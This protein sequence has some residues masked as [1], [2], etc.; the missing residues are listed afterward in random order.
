MWLLLGLLVVLCN[1]VSVVHGANNLLTQDYN[2]ART[3]ALLTEQIFTPAD[4][5]QFG[6]AVKWKMTLN[7]NVVGQPLYIEGFS[8]QGIVRNVVYVWT[9]NNKNNS[10]SG[11]YCFDAETGEMIWF[12]AFNL[13]RQYSTAT[14][15]I[16]LPNE[17]IFITT[18]DN[19]DF[20]PNWIHAL[21]LSTGQEL[22]GSPR[23]IDVT[24]PGNS[25]T[26][27]FL[28]NKQNARPGLLLLNGAIYM[29]FAYNS[30]NLP[31]RGWALKYT[32]SR[33]SGFS[34]A[35]VFCSAPTDPA[36]NSGGG[37]WQSGKGF[38][39]DGTHI[40]M[41]VGNGAFNP[42]AGDYGMCVIKLNESL[43]VDDYFVTSNFQALSDIDQD[44]GN[45]G[46]VLIP[47]SSL[48]FVGGTKYGKGHL[49][50]TL[51][52]GGWS[53]SASAP[54]TCV[55]TITTANNR[56][57]QN[58]IAWTGPGGTYIYLWSNGA[59]IEQYSLD[60]V[61]M[62]STPIH[63]G[64]A[65]T[66]GGALSITSDGTDN[67]ILWAFSRS[68][69]KLWALDPND[70]SQPPFWQGTVGT[71]PHFPFPAAI[72]GYVYIGDNASV[73]YA[74]KLNTN[75]TLTT[76]RSMASSASRLQS[77]ILG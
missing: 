51:D 41:T 6:L 10:P 9:N 5:Q 25:G 68:N 74:F 35:A 49:I 11:A 40:Y 57:G 1:L 38:M 50:N 2:N 33:T 7:S 17:I 56:V 46:P 53:G 42:N 16:D 61:S 55:Q 65:D 12:T 77:L 21:D 3:G 18:K 19:T 54:D 76:G 67:G 34:S 52:M 24:F 31:Y 30:D 26:I 44:T 20:G 70:V 60:G 23:K 32:Y 28:N 71:A 29:G 45:S 62:S 72:N 43:K 39:S 59:T 36:P 14:P 48:L 37:I 13:T 66:T 75:F 4:V 73:L 47:G 22:L 58:P 63:R 64:S 69:G 15:V 8:I 27:S